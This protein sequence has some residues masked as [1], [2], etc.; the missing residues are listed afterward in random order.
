MTDMPKKKYGQPSTEQRHS[1][2]QARRQA[3]DHCSS[4]RG[5]AAP[6]AAHEGAPEQQRVQASEETVGKTPAG[7]RVPP[8]YAN[9]KIDRP[10]RFRNSRDILNHIK[11]SMT[12]RGHAR[13]EDIINDILSGQS[14]EDREAIFART[15]ERVQ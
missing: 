13:K 14:P 6:E 12:E 9:E 11:H 3:T 7:K 8:L 1:W 2:R 10:P 15:L 4:G 5:T